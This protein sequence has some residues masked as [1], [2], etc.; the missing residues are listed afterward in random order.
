MNL[1]IY[2]EKIY[3]W[4]GDKAVDVAFP[5]QEQFTG[6]TDDF[7][8]RT[9]TKTNMFLY[10]ESCFPG[11]DDAEYNRCADEMMRIPN[12]VNRFKSTTRRPLSE[13]D[14]YFK[15]E[16]DNYIQEFTEIVKNY[17]I[18]MEQDQPAEQS[19]PEEQKEEQNNQEQKQQDQQEQKQQGQPQQQPQQPAQNQQPA[20]NTPGNQTQT[21]DIDPRVIIPPEELRTYRGTSSIIA[22]INSMNLPVKNPETGYTRQ[23]IIDATVNE[24]KNK[25]DPKSKTDGKIPLD[26]RSPGLKDPSNLPAYQFIATNILRAYT[27]NAYAH[28]FSDELDAAVRVPVY[29]IRPETITKINNATFHQNPDRNKEIRQRITDSFF[30][31]QKEVYMLRAK[32]AIYK[33]AKKEMQANGNRRVVFDVISGKDYG[34]EAYS[35]IF[36]FLPSNDADIDSHMVI[37]LHCANVGTKEEY[38][39][40]YSPASDFL[41]GDPSFISMIQLA[42]KCAKQLLPKDLNNPTPISEGDYQYTGNRTAEYFVSNGLID[43]TIPISKN[44]I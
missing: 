16:D 43:K 18:M 44:S 13:F 42:D 9:Y 1:Q 37:L 4:D 20:N 34:K 5:V 7:I 25:Y 21:S 2:N 14:H 36:R 3:L 29:S 22:K 8:N 41:F 38:I 6:I 28:D 11:C 31:A 17:E 24:W 35:C 30:Y 10:L 23:E 32:N 39:K 27:S 40:K 26:H 19:Q 12:M 15:S 33:Q